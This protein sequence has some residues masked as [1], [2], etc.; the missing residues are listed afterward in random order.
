VLTTRQFAARHDDF[1]RLGATQVHVFKSPVAALAPL[2]RGPARVPYDVVA[3]SRRV[4]YRLYGI[5][6]S[7]ASLR[8]LFTRRGLARVAEARRAGLRPRWRDALRDGVGGSPADFLIGPDGAIL[9]A[10]Y[11][12]H[13]VDSVPPA[14]ALG[15]IA[16]AQQA[17][18]AEQ[19]EPRG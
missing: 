15:W 16:E 3:D 8:A 2:G 7:L 17:Q 19:A 11:G 10:H 18:H 5:P 9:R 14:T 6:S 12:A 1:V 4:A 13:F